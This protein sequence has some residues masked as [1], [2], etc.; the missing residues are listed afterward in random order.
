MRIA[1]LSTMREFYGGEV[2]L[3]SLAAGMVERGHSVSCA[4]RP[5]SMLARQ[6]IPTGAEIR[7][8]PMVDWFDPGT[9][10]RLGKWLRAG[11][12]DLLHTHLPRDYYIAA[13]LATGCPVH[14]VGTR[15]HLA[16]I[17]VAP[18]KRPFLSRF[19]RWVAVSEAVH[20]SLLRSRVVD[21]GR[22]VTIHN[23]VDPVVDEKSESIAAADLRRELALVGDA[24]LVGYV[25]KLSPAKGLETLIPAFARVAGSH[26]KARLVLVGDDDGTGRYANRLAS[27]AAREGVASR[28]I[29]CGYRPGADRLS[30]AFD[31]QV[32][33]S[34]AEPFG[35]VT[36]EALARGRAVIATRTG[37]SA[38][39]VR[40]GKEG[41]LVPASDI[42]SLAEALG[43]LLGSP[44]LRAGLGENGCRR[45]TEV[46]SRRRMIDRTESLYESALRG[47]PVAPWI[48]RS[49]PEPRDR[50]RRSP[51]VRRSL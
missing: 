38:E 20:Q 51:V 43:R 24:L 15:H 35:L 48:S 10:W 19:E 27:L 28:V 23:G 7:E 31:V 33:P 1:Y 42:E 44:A 49:V 40:D 29:F 36:L 8:L 41:L 39:I 14:L 9:L 5:D 16:P 26:R 30:R 13:A 6:L 22:I 3:R 47:V 2:C 32:V 21:P 34:L 46:F 50:G 4:V 17:S 37:G 12:F 18:L 11:K 25:G 45:V